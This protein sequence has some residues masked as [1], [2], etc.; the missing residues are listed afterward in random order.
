MALLLTLLAAV[1]R[2][3]FKPKLLLFVRFYF[4]KFHLNYKILALC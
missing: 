1:S 3:Q 2:S 4:S